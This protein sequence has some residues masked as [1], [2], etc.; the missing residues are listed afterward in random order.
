MEIDVTHEEERGRF[1]VDLDDGEEAYLDYEVRADGTLDY[2]HTFVPKSHRGS[3]VAERMVL[4]AL[5]HAREKGRKITPSCPYVRHI[6][7]DEHP[8]YASLLAREED[9][10]S[11]SDGPTD[12]G[13]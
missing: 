11:G 12:S 8:E 7:E 3:G 4:E 1:V 9:G 5:E 6:V 10:E 2:A 13:A